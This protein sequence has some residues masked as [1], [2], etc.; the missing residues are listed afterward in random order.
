M[1]FVCSE[2]IASMFAICVF[3]SFL[4]SF[5]PYEQRSRQPDSVRVFIGLVMRYCNNVRERTYVNDTLFF[6]FFFPVDRLLPL[7]LW[8]C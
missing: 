2:I 4:I 8:D 5:S 3:F 7:L 6:D 1:M